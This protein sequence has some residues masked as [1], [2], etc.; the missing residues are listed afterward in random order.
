M[1]K[2]DGKRGIP[3]FAEAERKSNL[4]PRAESTGKR[5]KKKEAQ[6]EGKGARERKTGVGG[7]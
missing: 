5:H 7:G 1:D 2:E 3:V 4:K 6:A